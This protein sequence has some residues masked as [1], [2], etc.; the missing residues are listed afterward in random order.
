MCVA[1]VNNL[2]E[3]REYVRKCLTISSAQTPSHFLWCP[4]IEPLE[5]KK[6]KQLSTTHF[7]HHTAITTHTHS[8]SHLSLSQAHKSLLTHTSTPHSNSIPSYESYLHSSQLRTSWDC[9]QSITHNRVLILKV[10]TSQT[11]KLHSHFSETSF[12]STTLP[13][14][15]PS[16]YPSST[17]PLLH[18]LPH[19]TFDLGVLADDDS[20][21]GYS[22]LALLGLSREE[23]ESIVH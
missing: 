11:L 5:E 13:P 2:L 14:P 16:P 21:Q 23:G 7:N 20:L 1:E 17:L 9:P 6:A 19:P 12:P 10:N 18:P 15:L 3:K 22:V 8:L 4:E